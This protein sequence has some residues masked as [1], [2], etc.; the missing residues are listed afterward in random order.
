MLEK[1]L[2]GIKQSWMCSYCEP[3]T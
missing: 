3:V 2:Q 1:K